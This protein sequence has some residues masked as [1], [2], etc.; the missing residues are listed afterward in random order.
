MGLVKTLKDFA[1]KALGGSGK[2]VSLQS[3]DIEDIRLFSLLGND[4]R[5][6][7][8][9]KDFLLH[10]YGMNPYVFMVI[11]RICQ[12]LVQI[13]KLL[14]DRN[15]QV[16]DNPEFLELFKQPNFKEKG[17]AFLYRASATY[18]AT[19]EC[20]VVRKQVADEPDQYFVPINYNV[21]INENSKGEVISYWV[22]MFGNSETYLPNEVLHIHK[23]DIT[24]DTNHGFSTLRAT[25]KTWESN[26]EVWASE[27]SLHKNKGIAGVLYSDGN[28]PMTDT[29]QKALQE[30]Y[31][32]EFT[33]TDSFGKV[34]ISTSK[35][36]YVQMGMNPTDLQSIETRLEH[37]RTICAS[38]NVDSKLFGDSQATTYNNMAEAKRAFIIDAVIP[39]S[40]VLLPSLV[41]FMSRSFFQSYTMVLDEDTILELQIVIEQKSARLGREVIQGILTSE[42]ARKMLYPELVEELEDGE[43]SSEGNTGD[44]GDVLEEDSA[45]EAA[46]AQAQ[47]ALRGSVGGVQGI[48]QIQQSVEAGSTSRESAITILMQIYG[49]DEPTA[50]QILG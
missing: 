1:A 25:R 6:G 44:D 50:N 39:L 21:I 42:Q 7:T 23:P 29:E 13:D 5:F 31:D 9:S 47:A 19:G 32:K 48:L 2:T 41:Q 17:A 15:E 49:F 18:L 22:T 11:D 28:R 24:F 8:K 46:N 34:K 27:A 36:G 12:R 30:K 4:Y 38:F 35:L 16:I 33:S 20:F 14:L 40:K 26:N 43:G 3:Q 45:A 37:L 10:A